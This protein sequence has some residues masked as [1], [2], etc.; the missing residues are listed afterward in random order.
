MTRHRRRMLLGRERNKQA[1]TNT[2][3]PAN[4]LKSQTMKQCKPSR[5]RTESTTNVNQAATGKAAEQQSGKEVKPS[6]QSSKASKKA[7]NQPSKQA[8][9]NQAT[10]DRTTK[11]T[12]KQTNERTNERMNEQAYKRTKV[13]GREEGRN[14]GRTEGRRKDCGK[15]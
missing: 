5:L 1:D 10:H 12:T 9:N 8:S 14:D 4:K 15:S 13:E 7:S 2:H 6:T 3:V 11:R